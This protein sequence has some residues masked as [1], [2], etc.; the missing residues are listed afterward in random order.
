M[1]D[2]RILFVDDDNT[3]REVLKRELE[4]FGLEVHAFADPAK[5][6]EHAAQHPADLALIDLRMP[7]MDGMELLS[8][9]RAIDEAMPV[10]ISRATAPCAR[11]SRP[12]AAARTT[13]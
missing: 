13:S 2:R 9:L 4:D 10:V 5:A 7:G 12:C 1:K 6:L 11:R 8:R 3:L